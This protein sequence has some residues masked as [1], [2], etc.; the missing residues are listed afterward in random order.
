MCQLSFVYLLVKNMYSRESGF[1]G[2]EGSS[3]KS[4]Q[5][6]HFVNREVILQFFQSMS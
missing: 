4:S 2:G 3:M 5:S 1:P 6:E